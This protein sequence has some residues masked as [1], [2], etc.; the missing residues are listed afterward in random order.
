MKRYAWLA[1][2]CWAL[3]AAARLPE[4]PGGCE[5]T[6][7]FELG[8]NPALEVQVHLQVRGDT[9]GTTEFTVSRAWGG[10]TAGGDDL[11]RARAWDANGDTLAVE[12][13]APEVWRVRHPP[14]ESLTFG[15]RIAANA[16]QRDASRSVN[17]RPILNDSLLHFYGE[18]GL[19]TPRHVQSD[20]RRRIAFMWEGFDDAG[21]KV[22]H[23]FGT[24][25]E[26]RAMEAT[27]HELRQAVYMA[28]AIRLIRR[29][30]RQHPL[31]IAIQG[32]SWPFA[33]DAFA[34]L[35]ARIVRRER[36]FFDDF[37]RPYFLVTLIEVGEA[38]PGS[39]SLGGTGLT[40]SFSLSMLPGTTL[41][42]PT[43]GTALSVAQLLAHEMFH[44]WNGNLIARADP[45]EL[46][47]WFSE[48]FTD[49]YARRMLFRDGL[50]DA[51]E[52]AHLMES[53]CYA[54]LTNPE[55]TAPNDSI[56][57]GFWRRPALGQLPY[58]RGD[59]VAMIL[60]HAIR[61]RSRGR[62]SLDQ[63][64]RD[65]VREGRRGA[66]VSTEGLLERFAREA[67]PETAAQLRAII[68]DGV[69][70]ALAPKIF[71]PCLAMRYE[72]VP[73]YDLGFDFDASAKSGVVSGVRPGSTAALAGLQ[74]GQQLAG[75]SVHHGDIE[76]EVRIQVRA[77]EQVRD[78]TYVP[79]GPPVAAPRF[80]VRPGATR[81]RCRCL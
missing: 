43:G 13:A 79:A 62:R 60:D 65:L 19:V 29:D 42:S 67:G 74:D 70:P 35:A 47:Y 56:R 23:S 57:A 1:A 39:R 64:M 28:G 73:S 78:V 68:V 32:T 3:P 31:W 9:T 45:E 41:E 37:A 69:V 25:T 55:R 46:V 20:V 14:G 63:V 54:L 18:L 38:Q 80:S 58:Q 66:R 15:Y 48:G 44:E 16:H 77:G 17:R 36:A 2:I 26:P 50:V 4:A 51:A 34:D 7:R 76:R 59:V 61:R 52:Y 27:L 81:A 5:L 8:R 6:Y 53:K 21:W 11:S 30:I 40:N 71:E 10:V 75:Y 24:G 33:D 72:N 12:H 49:F 22:A